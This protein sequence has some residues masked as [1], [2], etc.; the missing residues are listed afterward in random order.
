MFVVLSLTAHGQRRRADLSVNT[1]P[2]PRSVL[3]FNPGDDRTI[4]DWKQI[5]D[6][7]ARLD[8][9]SDRVQ[10]Q[11]F[12]QSTL[13][14]PLVA[15]FISAPENIR[16]LEK[17]KEI[18]ARLADPRQVTSELERDRLIR[19][20]K[21]VVVISCSIHSTEIVASQMSTQLAYNL[22]SANDDDTLSIL[23][24]T[25]LILIPSPNPDGVDIVANHYRKTLGTP[26]EGREPPELYHHYAGHDDNR[27]WFM[28]DLKE[29]KAV[30]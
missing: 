29:T 12:G 19:E 18:Q 30:T 24:N 27:D 6:Y 9:A 22:A 15:A 5:T 28:I 26:A 13:G 11:T 20:G 3:G 25:I 21:T 23:R 2:S 16:N 10:L 17:Y 8:K 14:R 4:A 1:I 7:F